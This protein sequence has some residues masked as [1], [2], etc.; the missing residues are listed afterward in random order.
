VSI[1]EVK[2]MENRISVFEDDFDR[3]EGRGGQPQP[4]GEILAELLAQYQARFP[5]AQVSVVETAGAV[6]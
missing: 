4:I 1:K 6:C 5:E 2:I 3:R